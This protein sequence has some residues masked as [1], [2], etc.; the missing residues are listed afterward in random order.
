MMRSCC[1]RTRR[2][3]VGRVIGRLEQVVS[4]GSSPSHPRVSIGPPGGDND[5]G[6]PLFS[7]VERQEVAIDL[8][9]VARL[10]TVG[11]L[12]LT[13]ASSSAFVQLSVPHGWGF[14]QYGASSPPCLAFRL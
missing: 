7:S 14:S 11:C 6:V 10:G 12:P 13:E 5:L 4:H 9:F 3:P 1:E 2:A 8:G